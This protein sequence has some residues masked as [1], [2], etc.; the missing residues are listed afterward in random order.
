MKFTR[1][2]IIDINYKLKT[3]CTLYTIIN[4][5]L[6]LHNLHEKQLYILNIILNLL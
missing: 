1:V 6:Y 2:T 4:I 3:L 5:I